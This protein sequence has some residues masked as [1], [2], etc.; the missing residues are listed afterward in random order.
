VFRAA[1][2]S[3]A[4]EFDE[5]KIGYDNN[6]FVDPQQ[7]A[8]TFSL[9]A[10]ACAAGRRWAGCAHGSLCRAFQGDDR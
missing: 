3:S 10:R 7:R 5:V 9:G 6:G 1:G 4:Q 2:G 8:A